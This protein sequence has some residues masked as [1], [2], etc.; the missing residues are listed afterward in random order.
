[1]FLT[2]A[3]ILNQILRLEIP[4]GGASMVRISTSAPFLRFV[5]ILFGPLYGG[6]IASLSDVMSFFI[7]NRSGAGFLWPLTV[8]AF[9]RGAVT[10]FLWHKIKSI[11]FKLLN[12]AY[13]LLF[14]A[15][16][17][18]GA[19]NLIHVNFFPYNEYSQF[20]LNANHNAVF[21]TWAIIIIGAVA[22]LLHIGAFKILKRL[23]KPESFSLYLRL[24]SCLL[25]PGVFFT[26]VNTWILIEMLSLQMGFIYFW[27]P[28]IVTEVFSVVYTVYVLIVLINLYKRIFNIDLAPQKS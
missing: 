21:F 2:I 13:L 23:D 3:L 22:L 28:R 16:V 11:N 18:V 7:S 15:I 20:I 1:M 6:I 8:V 12:I 26:T 10:A 4:V 9:C 14:G 19:I 27:I 24:M 5:G 17:L 25:L